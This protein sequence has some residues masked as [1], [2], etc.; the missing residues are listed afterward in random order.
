M[1]RRELQ[2][3]TIKPR[4]RRMCQ[5]RDGVALLKEPAL[6]DL[7]T[8]ELPPLWRTWVPSTI[9]RA[10]TTKK[11]ESEALLYINIHL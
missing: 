1:A 5:E 8:V 4:W 3:R 10:Q 9:L 11:K 7:T 2:Q 6:R